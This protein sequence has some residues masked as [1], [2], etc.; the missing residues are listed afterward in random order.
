M[1]SKI[2]SRKFVRML[3]KEIKS[4]KLWDKSWDMKN[5]YSTP[6]LFD[7]MSNKWSQR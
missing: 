5:V 3:S 1:I 4:Q 6:Y 7:K 2:R